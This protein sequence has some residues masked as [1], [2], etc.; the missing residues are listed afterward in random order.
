MR[1]TEQR[2]AQH[3]RAD[4][5]SRSAQAGAVAGR[6]LCGGVA[7]RA[8]QAGCGG[9]A[10]GWH[11]RQLRDGARPLRAA[12]V[13]R[14]GDWGGYAGRLRAVPC[15]P[16]EPPCAPHGEQRLAAVRCRVPARHACEGDTGQSRRR[17]RP[18][19]DNQ[20]LQRNGRRYLPPPA[21]WLAGGC[22]SCSGRR[23]GAPGLRTTGVVPV[24]RGFTPRRGAGA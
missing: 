6:A 7:S 14:Q 2:E 1:R 21:V 10:E 24:L 20:R 9:H 18:H 23:T 11:V 4:R 13:R 16:C 5:P 3:C 17:H 19:R 15:G 22:A 8:A 12:G